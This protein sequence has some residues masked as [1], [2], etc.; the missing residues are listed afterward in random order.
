MPQFNNNGITIQ[1]GD[2]MTPAPSGDVENSRDVIVTVLVEPAHQ[3]NTVNIVYRKNKDTER[4]LRATKQ[5]L[6]S[7][8]QKDYFDARFPTLSPGD[9][10]EYSP[11]CQC[12]GK[13]NDP[14]VKGKHV[15]N[16]RIINSKQRATS[17]PSIS[18]I[19][20]KTDLGTPK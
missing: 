1:L 6:R 9:V 19:Q 3:S 11:V 7:N 4:I 16:F 5:A 12:A 20:P 15:A 14:R 10:I 2:N 13:L 17:T 8:Q 18:T